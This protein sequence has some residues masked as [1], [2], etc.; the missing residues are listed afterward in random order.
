MNKNLNNNPTVKNESK[1]MKNGNF[2]VPK[3]ININV[4]LI[5]N[6]RKRFKRKVREY[7]N[8]HLDD[9]ADE[10]LTF[11][12]AKEILINE[13]DGTNHYSDEYYKTKWIIRYNN[14]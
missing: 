3:G 14:K 4:N 2:F 11:S 8:D 10:I 1:V 6:Y 9:T 13:E 5:K 12:K 7:L